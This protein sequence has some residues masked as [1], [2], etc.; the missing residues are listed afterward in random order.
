[1]A[2]EFTTN[3]TACA[4][5]V[6]GVMGFTPPLSAQ[7]KG[8]PLI[9]SVT[10]TID[11]PSRPLELAEFP[12]SLVD[13]VVVP[14]PGEI[15][16]VMEKLGAPNW[17]QHLELGQADLPTDRAVLALIFGA[18]VAEGFLA[19]QGEDEE[20]VRTIGRRLLK[21]AAA[22]GIKDRVTPHYR[23]IDEATQAGNWRVVRA[24]IDRT[25]QTVRNAMVEL[26]D[27]DLATLV[28]LGGWLR[29]TEILTAVI[30][31]AYSADRAEVLNQPDLVAHFVA[32]AGDLA[33]PL[34][35]HP[36]VAAI[37]VGLG[38]IHRL[39]T[40]SEPEP[41]ALA[42]DE[43]ALSTSEEQAPR[44]ADPSRRGA[45]ASAADD[46]EATTADATEPVQP[47]S[48][49]AGG[50]DEDAPDSAAGEDVAV[51]A[52]GSPTSLDSEAVIRVGEICGELLQRF[53][54]GGADGEGGGQ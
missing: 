43:E 47:A 49:T 42:A 30:A 4:V 19:V 48:E 13:Q 32:S 28:S 7:V 8:I 17:R 18:T 23:S 2:R 40:F 52:A 45:E 29:G 14:V 6:L 51:A 36:D 34:N 46:A 11:V 20:A 21:L 50:P 35:E 37:T 39:M 53:Y 3:L 26:Q 12:G 54:S 41:S 22:L 10:A 44:V 5:F 33:A 24:E 16:A 9:P 15:F 27:G 25:Q 38:D 31:E 1:M